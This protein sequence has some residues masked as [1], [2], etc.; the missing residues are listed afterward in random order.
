MPS[1][2][3]SYVRHACVAS[4]KYCTHISETERRGSP[5]SESTEPL[6]PQPPRHVEPT[7]RPV[8]HAKGHQAIKRLVIPSD[9][10]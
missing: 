2:T 4:R 5:Y 10:R 7:R 8:S 1:W 3:W 9:A 6:P